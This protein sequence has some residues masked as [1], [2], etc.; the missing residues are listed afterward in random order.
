MQRGH[1]GARVLPLS[2]GVAPGL[3]IPG[4]S[5]TRAQV[6]S[7]S[8]G[9]MGALV[10]SPWG[11]GATTVKMPAAHRASRYWRVAST[12]VASGD[13]F[14]AAHKGRDTAGRGRGGGGR[15]ARQAPLHTCTCGPPRNMST[16]TCRT[17]EGLGGR[18]GNSLAYHHHHDR[19]PPP[20][21][22]RA[23]P[24]PRVYR[25]SVGC[26]ASKPPPTSNHK[27]GLTP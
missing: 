25:P 13:R 26:P 18:L 17:G 21:R 24:S 9:G 1:M 19:A 2:Y 12:A 5:A 3:P 20:G 22:A 4:S 16:C 11:G 23:G 10:P 15:R 27:T 8:W 7:R 14:R 6:S